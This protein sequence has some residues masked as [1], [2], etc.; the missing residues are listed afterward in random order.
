VSTING[1][2]IGMVNTLAIE[3]A[4]IRVNAIHPGIVGDSWYWAAKPAEVLEAYRSR[5]PTGILATQADVVDAIDFLLRN[6]SMNGQQ[7]GIDGGWM[8][9]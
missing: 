8:L 4:P 2:I 7:I 6:K 5:T 9:T 1:G 3:L